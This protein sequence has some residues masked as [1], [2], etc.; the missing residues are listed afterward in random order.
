M[1]KIYEA[2]DRKNRSGGHDLL[3]Q[4]YPRISST[5]VHTSA[6][7]PLPSYTHTHL[8]RFPLVLK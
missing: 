1:R 5:S 6:R 8:L 4:M 7:V 3:G 2:E